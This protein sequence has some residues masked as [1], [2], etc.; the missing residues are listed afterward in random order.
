M[1]SNEISNEVEKADARKLILS[2]LK[3][4]PAFQENGVLT[5]KIGEYFKNR[6]PQSRSFKEVFPDTTITQFL[7]D[8]LSDEVKLA[9]DPS[10]PIKIFARANSALSGEFQEAPAVNASSKIPKKLFK[11]RAFLLALS[12]EERKKFSLDGALLLSLLR[13][14]V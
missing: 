13:D 9:K 7:K 5:S 12:E 8:N 3:D 2:I 1:S 11:L 4:E 14:E 10:N 6:D